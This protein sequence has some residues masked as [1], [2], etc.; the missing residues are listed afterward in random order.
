MNGNNFSAKDRD[1]DS[2][3]SNCANAYKGGWW[4]SACHSANLNG[5][6][7]KGNNGVAGSSGCGATCIHYNSWTGNGK[8]THDKSLKFSYMMMRKPPVYPECKKGFTGKSSLVIPGFNRKVTVD[9]RDG[10]VVFQKRSSNT[11][12]FFTT[13]SD[14]KNG[15]GDS[16][17]SWLGNDNL[18]KLTEAGYT[19]AR[20]YIQE[21]DGTAGYGEWDKNHISPATKNHEDTFCKSVRTHDCLHMVC[22][23]WL[24]TILLMR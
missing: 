9:C 6:Y 4:Y 12:N 19:Q 20:I 7:G 2:W 8:Y 18:N 10:W 17:N 13:W 3:S 24:Y 11:V 5:Y 14:Y 16:A 23:T 21:A 22:D 15:F 1:N